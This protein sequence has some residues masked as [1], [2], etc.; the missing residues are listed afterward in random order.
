MAFECVRSAQ[1]KH[2]KARCLCGFFARNQQTQVQTV[3]GRSPPRESCNP[4]FLDFASVA[5]IFDELLRILNADLRRSLY[6][7]RTLRR[8]Y[9]KI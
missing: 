3:V 5:Q 1:V 4:N 7:E 6:G 2:K 8:V 9:M